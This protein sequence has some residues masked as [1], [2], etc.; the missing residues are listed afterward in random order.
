MEKYFSPGELNSNTLF[1]V[2]NETCKGLIYTSENDAP[3]EAFLTPANGRSVAETRI[4]TFGL[5]DELR[6]ADEQE[7][8]SFFENA[9]RRAAWH[10][11]EQTKRAET[12]RQ[13]KDLLE[14]NLRSLAVYRS[15]TINIAI[16]VAGVDVAGNVAGIKTSSVET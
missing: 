10:G 12:F 16:F 15:G 2:L 4:D 14:K 6:Q 3:V 1:Q 11:E 8:V 7:R 5:D 13:L 9:T